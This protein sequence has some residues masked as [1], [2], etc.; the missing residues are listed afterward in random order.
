MPAE[1]RELTLHGPASRIDEAT[2]FAFD[3]IEENRNCTCKKNVCECGAR[4]RKNRSDQ[5]ELRQRAHQAA[6]EAKARAEAKK[7]SEWAEAD[8]A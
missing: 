3:R 7:Q 8:N 5:D 1:A 4:G 6:Q 2:D